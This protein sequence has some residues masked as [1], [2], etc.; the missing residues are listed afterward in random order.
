MRAV[1]DSGP[2]IR[3]LQIDYDDEVEAETGEGVREEARALAADIGR[4]LAVP[5]AERLRDGL[6]V[7]IAGPPNAGKSSLFNALIGS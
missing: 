2:C 7:V 1:I 5:P 3:T 6:R 4:A